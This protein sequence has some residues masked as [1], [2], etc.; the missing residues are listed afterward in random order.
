MGLIKDIAK[1]Y[2]FFS[3]H[4]TIET[5]NSPSLFRIQYTLL[6]TIKY[7]QPL[8]FWRDWK[9]EETQVWKAGLEE[10]TYYELAGSCWASG[11]DEIHM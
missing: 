4:L 6:I 1:V 2:R 3:A 9:R 5:L 10:E 8:S 11:Q 7:Y